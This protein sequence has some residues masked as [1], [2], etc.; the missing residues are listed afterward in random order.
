MRSEYGGNCIKNTRQA[1]H[2]H[3]SMQR[4]VNPTAAARHA[5]RRW[6]VPVGAENCLY[7]S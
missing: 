2:V 7:A 6:A 1:V 3:G 5:T 4:A